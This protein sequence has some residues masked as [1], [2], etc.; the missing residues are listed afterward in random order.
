MNSVL[1]RFAC[2]CFLGGSALAFQT[3][4]SRPVR[5]YVE[6]FATKTGAEKLQENVTATLRKL[7][8]ISLVSDESKADLILGGGGEIWVTGYRSL[9]PR[10]GRLP[11]GGAPVYGGY[12]SVELRSKNG[13]T[14]WSYLVTPGSSPVDVSKDL[15]KRVAKHLAEA[16][17]QAEETLPAEPLPQPTTIL[18]GAGATFPLPVYEKWFANYRRENAEVQIN[19]DPIGSEAGIR[20]LLTGS[21]DFGA[22]DCPVVFRDLAP[23]D[24]SKYLFFP[25][26]VGAVVPIVNLPGL[27]QQISF[28]PEA[29]AGIFLGKIRKWND[30]VLRRANRGIRL[31]D[32]D[33]VVVHRAEGSGTSYAWT[34]YLS[35]ISPEWKAQAGAALAPKWPTGRSASGNDGVAKLVKELGGSIGYVEFIYALQNHLTYGKVGNRNGEFV[36]ASLESI[37][38]AVNGSSEIGVDLK[39]SIVDAPG[40]GAYPIASF[41]WLVVPAR[42]E[43]ATK[44]AAINNLLRWIFGPGQKQAAALGYLALPR[45]VVRKAENALSRID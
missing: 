28:T 1:L 16:L 36:E 24:E 32:L 12:L 5:L 23:G 11:S 7:N 13:A 4:S 19:Y 44:R 17:E 45:D 29:L 15:S 38:A 39:A 41:T 14:L 9:N 34:D 40:P 33:I 21:I 10:S 31:P 27:T 6:K 25:S 3:A 26:V 37:A 2:C 35:T 22:S 8:S 20:R 30:P 43:D 18:N 42:I